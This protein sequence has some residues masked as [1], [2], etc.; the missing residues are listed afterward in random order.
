MLV[1]FHF[2]GLRWFMGVAGLLGCRIF[3]LD[4]MG[5]VFGKEQFALG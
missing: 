1:P 4:L 2:L 5:Q 3:A